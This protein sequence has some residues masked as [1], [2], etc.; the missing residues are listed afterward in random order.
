L[1][2]ETIWLTEKV[3]GPITEAFIIK[4]NEENIELQKQYLEL[5]AQVQEGD[6]DAL[7][8]LHKM[9]TDFPSIA[10]YHRLRHYVPNSRQLKDN[11]L[12]AID[13]GELDFDVTLDGT[14]AP[15]VDIEA[16]LLPSLGPNY[17]RGRRSWIDITP[18]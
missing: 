16:D 10:Q 11:Q 17:Q 7:L 2:R 9:F 8:R 14:P 1:T 5:V 3:Y 4:G 18:E 15:V 12:I 6:T 13:R